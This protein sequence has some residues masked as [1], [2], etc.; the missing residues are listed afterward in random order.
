MCYVCVLVSSISSTYHF[1]NLFDASSISETMK[2]SPNLCQ[3]G[4]FRHPSN[5]SSNI[6]TKINDRNVRSSNSPISNIVND[7]SYPPSIWC[8]DFAD[9]LIV[10]GC[11]DGRLEFWEASTAKFKVIVF[12]LIFGISH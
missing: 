1:R 6:K 9:N 8:M 4:H 2:I 10:L 5:E 11:S 7:T 3:I 12:I